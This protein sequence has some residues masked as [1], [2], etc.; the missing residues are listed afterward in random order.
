MYAIYTRQSKDKKDSISIETQIEFCKREILSDDEYKIYDDKGFSGGNIN[1]PDFQELMRDIKSG[2]ITKVIVYRLDRISRS[3][4]NFASMMQLFDEYKVEFVSC[5]EKLDTTTAAGRMVVNIL[6]VFAQ[7]ERESTQQRI[8]D[9]YYERGKRGVF[10]GGNTPF[11]YDYDNIKIANKKTSMLIKNDDSAIVEKIFDMYVNQNMSLIAISHYM[12]EHK[13]NVGGKNNKGCRSQY[14]SRIIRNPVYAQADSHI[15]H[16]LDMNNCIMV[17]DINEFDGKAGLISYGDNDLNKFSD[18]AGY[19]VAVGLHDWIIPSDLW[20]K[21]Q[22][23]VRNNKQIANNGTSKNTWLSGLTKCGYCGFAMTYKSQ[24]IRKNKALNKAGYLRCSGRANKSCDAEMPYL[25][26][27]NVETDIF[28]ALVNHV[29]TNDIK[30][31]NAKDDSKINYLKLEL[32]MLDK[33]I[34]NL[35]NNLMEANEITMIYIN[36][37]INELHNKKNEITKKLME[38][39][40][41]KDSKT[42]YNVKNDFEKWDELGIE[43]KKEIA[44]TYI[45][46]IKFYKDNLFEITFK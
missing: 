11:G 27:E 6:V 44:R 16:Y 14:I 24:T 40:N 23:K 20:L 43:E 2:L 30:I 15:Y 5:T 35:I 3:I 33:K 28:N 13:I 7:Y 32:S 38:C 22:Y 45:D 34:D 9:N 21:A 18:L 41:K 29:K 10:L 19:Y 46:E 36:K 17:N 8:K 1:R 42:I 39:E 26:L 37:A 4:L 12:N 25:I 31:S